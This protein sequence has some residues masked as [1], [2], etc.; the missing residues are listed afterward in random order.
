MPALKWYVSQQRPPEEP[1]L[2]AIDVTAN[3]A[4]IATADPS[5]IHGRSFDLP[6]PPQKLVLNAEG[7]VQLGEVLA[8]SYLNRD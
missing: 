8:R 1:G 3:L 6:P 2:S 4:A 5:F 7:I